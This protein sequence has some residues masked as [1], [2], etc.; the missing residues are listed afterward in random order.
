M[1]AKNPTMKDVA[2]LA[3]FATATVSLALRNSRSLPPATRNKIW[4]AARRL[5][6]K[7]NPLVSALMASRRSQ[8]PADHHPVLALVTSHPANDPWRAQRTFVELVTGAGHRASEL[9]YRLEEFSLRSAGM[10]PRRFV[11][12][13]RARNIHGLLINPLPH[14]ERK[15][16]LNVSDF[17]V[18]GLGASIKWPHIERVSNDHFQS[19]MLA[20]AKCRELGYRRVGFVVSREMSERLEDR[21]LAGYLL[22]QH[23]LAPARRVPPLM[24]EQTSEILEALPIWHRREKPDAVIFGF[25]DLRY[26]TQLPR[27]VGLVALSV[28]QASGPLTGVFQDSFAIGAVAVNHLVGRLQQ[29]DFGADETARL[30]LMAGRWAPGRTAC[31]PGKLRPILDN[32]SVALPK[33]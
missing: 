1:P 10:T 6:Y 33:R 11:D 23:Q 2:A 3:G 17:A 12:V 8:R 14:K 4:A 5:R 18:V 21:W 24:P 28:H 27:Q 31:G 29:T 26:Q 9:G 7:R 25:L 22:A 20:M 32:F 16:A 19:A 15:L 13:L 30:H